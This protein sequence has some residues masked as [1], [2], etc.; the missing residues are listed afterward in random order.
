MPST[1][2][3]WKLEEL[4]KNAAR[5]G[6]RIIRPLAEDVLQLK[7]ESIGLFDRILLDAPCTGFGA[8]R[9]NP[10]IK[11]HRHPKDPY[12]MSQLQ[13]EMLS[14]ASRCSK[15]AEFSSMRPALFLRTKMKWLPDTFRKPIPNSESRV[16]RIIFPR[17]AAR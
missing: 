3:E 10:D 17:A 15:A 1:F 6:V 4:V 9:R 7:P 8:I 5:Q 11:W 14:H 12:R 16:Y 2:S 13:K